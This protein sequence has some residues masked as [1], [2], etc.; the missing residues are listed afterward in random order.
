MLEHDWEQHGVGQP[1]LNVIA[2]SNAVGERMDVTHHGVRER[3]ASV[4]R[5]KQHVFPMRHIFR[6][7][8]GC[9]QVPEDELDGLFGVF[10]RRA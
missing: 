3:Y 10:A 5:R 2:P 4:E 6:I 8:V 9:L 1:V 7:I